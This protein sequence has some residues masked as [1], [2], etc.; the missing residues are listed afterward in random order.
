MT[1]GSLA[2]VHFSCFS[3]PFF[4]GSCLRILRLSFEASVRQPRNRYY[5]KHDYATWRGRLY[6]CQR[7]AWDL[8]CK[9]C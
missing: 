8:E 5:H 4:W 9:H 2:L 3:N 6:P 1:L 7:L